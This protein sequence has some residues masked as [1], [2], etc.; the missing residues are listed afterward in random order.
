MLIGWFMSL[1]KFI[2]F[3]WQHDRL[4]DEV[5]GTD[6]AICVHF[7]AFFD[8][9]DSLLIYSDILHGFVIWILVTIFDGMTVVSTCSALRIF[10]VLNVAIV[11][12]QYI[13]FFSL[14]L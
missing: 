13:I 12:R 14:M 2:G 4:F 1:A 6:C 5:S 10:E 11:V 7:L 3:Q 9:V 8:F